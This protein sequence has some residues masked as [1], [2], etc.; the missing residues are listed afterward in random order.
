MKKFTAVIAV[1]LFSTFSQA[2]DTGRDLLRAGETGVSKTGKVL[3]DTSKYVKG[4]QEIKVADESIGESSYNYVAFYV[5]GVLVAVDEVPPF[6]LKHDFGAYTRKAK[7]VALGVQF[8]LDRKVAEVS[9]AVAEPAASESLRIISPT[10]EE[11]CY[12]LKIIEVDV[13]L[14]AGQVQRVDFTVDGEPVGSDSDPPYRIEHDFGRG[15][16]PHRVRT[17]AVLTDGSRVSTEIRTSPLENSDYLIRTRLVTLDATVVDWRDRLVGN[18][19][20]EEFRVFEDGKEQSVTH[21]SI[22]ERPLRI[23]LLIDISESMSRYGRIERARESAKRFLDFLKPDQDKAAL[24]AFTDRVN[25][26]SGFTNNFDL[27]KKKIGDL[28]PIGGTAI[29]DALAQAAPMFDEEAG[30]KAIILIS[31]GYDEHS[32]ATVGEAVEE[33]RKSGI[34]IYSIAILESFLIMEESMAP[35]KTHRGKTPDMAPEDARRGDRKLDK[36]TDPRKLLFVGLADQTGGAAFF[37][38]RL[39]ELPQM[40]ERIAQEL[41]RQYSIGY[42]PVNTN[43]DGRWRKIAVKTTRSGLTV[44]TRRGY[45]GDK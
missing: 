41:R 36:E 45:Y 7:I 2:Q 21:F 33:S 3:L 40:F 18:L 11:Y 9:R 12:G 24:I 31:D 27:L 13:S 28:E 26:L 20:A 44:R 16:D 8:E 19:K 1:I 14:P 23:A 15:F 42:V 32:E 29:N 37:P 10:A 4:E 43:Y 6:S 34:K 22:E 38:K 30:R 5:D 17:V 25:V 35:P 39:M